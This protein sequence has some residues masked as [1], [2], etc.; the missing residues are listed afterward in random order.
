[1]QLLSK[2]VSNYE[3]R[4]E[5]LEDLWV[6]SQFLAPEDTIF[7]TT[8]R[9]IKVGNENNP[10]ITKKLIFVELLVKKVVFEN[11]VLRVSGEI[12]NETE[13]TAVGSSHT[14]T[15]EVNDNVKVNK[16]SILKF[17][18]NMLNDA[19]KS[20]KSLN[21]L[22]LFDKD[23]LIAVEFGEFSYRVLFEKRGLGSKKYTSEEVDE[24][25]E[26]F[27]LIEPYL[28]KDYSNIVIGAP[29]MFVTSFSK[30]LSDKN[31]K[32]VSFAY[33][34]I[35]SSSIQ[36]AIDEV[37]K[38]GILQENT[39]AKENEII[40]KLL[41]NIDKGSKFAYGEKNVFESIDNGSCETLLVTTKFIDSKRDNE[42]YKELNDKMRTVEQ[43]NGNLVIIQSKNE[44]GRVLDGLGSIGAILRY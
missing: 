33:S 1:M 35:N 12:Q 40:S 20:K 41:L 24:N 17:E 6:L 44:S 34:D 15:F 14:I 28:S 2:D 10:K 19:I 8:E 27:K 7:A 38:K 9:K 37:N 4:P 31:V 3:I 13:F 11:E 43:L 26:R 42:I 23:E 29:N 5:S 25:L 18:E 16:K 32:N 22:V 30:Y 39:I 21:F 36:K